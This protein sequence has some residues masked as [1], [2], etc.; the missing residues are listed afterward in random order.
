MNITHAAKSAGLAAATIL[1][2]VAGP[3]AASAAEP[4]DAPVK[5][6][7]APAEP[8]SAAP[9]AAEPPAAEPPPA[10]AEAAPAAQSLDDVVIAEARVRYQR[11]TELYKAGDFKLALIEF[12][13]SYE[14][15]PTFRIL[16]NIG[17]VNMQLNNYARALTAFE[18][19]LA[20][21]GDAV[22]A[23]RRESIEMELGLLRG[24]TAH[25]SVTSNEPG[26]E[27]RIDGVPVGHTPLASLLVDAGEHNITV[28][29][30]GRTESA[31]AVIAGKENKS[32]TID[33]PVEK[34]APVAPV[35]GPVVIHE[36]DETYT[37]S[38]AP[39]VGWVV[40]GV[41][42]AAAV[43]TGVAAL[44]A[45]SDLEDLKS[46]PTT[47]SRL[48]SASKKATALSVTTDVLAVSAVVMGGIS[49]YLTLSDEGVRVERDDDAGAQLRLGVGQLSLSGA[50]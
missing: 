5:P 6:V 7:P 3:R 8:P 47:A 32:L 23:E 46:G 21:G 45:Q 12:Q 44:A 27:V 9:P 15:A 2:L 36:G 28:S 13:R 16:Y 29:K 37:L 50:F 33:F 19:Y 11:G 35:A 26:A 20:E 4:D 42:T 30:N 22:S 14:T 38:T 24:R 43:G 41:V 25:V 10:D 1:A 39:I 31:Y 40:T 49:L 34:P 18:R 17:Q 48:D